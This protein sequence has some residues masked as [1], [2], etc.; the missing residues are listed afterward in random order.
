M[1]SVSTQM[2]LDMTDHEKSAYNATSNTYNVTSNN[3]KLTAMK[4]WKLKVRKKPVKKVNI[5]YLIKV[6][7]NIQATM[8]V[9]V[10]PLHQR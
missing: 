6:K 1:T 9:Q 10:L 7:L 2:E 3:L 4:T 5:A 8:K